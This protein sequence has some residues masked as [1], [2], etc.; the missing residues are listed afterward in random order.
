MTKVVERP[1]PTLKTERL[2]LRQLVAND[3]QDVFELRTNAEV[4][5]YIDRP[6]SRADQNGRAFIDRISK[7]V[8]SKT[9]V[10]WVISLKG[11]SKLIGTIC[12]WNFSSD[13]TTAEV[14]YELRPDCVRKGIMN[15]ALVA[16]LDFGF[17]VAQF[18]SIE[19]FTHKDNLGSKKL[20]NKNGFEEDKTRVDD[21]NVNN[22]I[23]IKAND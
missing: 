16:V 11:N 23:F 4:N 14:G 20:L 8:N 13:K 18:K 19:A 21:D 12:L 10:F 9:L 7:G 15:E 22:I 3:E 17:N 6:I 2:V 1:F 5:K